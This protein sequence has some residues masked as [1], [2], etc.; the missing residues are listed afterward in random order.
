M[1]IPIILAL[2]ALLLP[3][4][5]RLGRPRVYRKKAGRFEVENGGKKHG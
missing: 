1:S 4:A 5:D 3:A 2:A